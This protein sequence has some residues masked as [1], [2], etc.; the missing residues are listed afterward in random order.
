MTDQNIFDRLKKDHV[1]PGGTTNWAKLEK[2]GDTLKGTYIRERNFISPLYPNSNPRVFDIKDQNGVLVSYRSN[3]VLDE[4]FNGTKS[5][6]PIKPGQYV[7][8]TFLGMKP[9]KRGSM[10]DFQVCASPDIVDNSFKGAEFEEMPG[11]IEEVAKSFGG[12]VV[13]NTLPFESTPTMGTSSGADQREML[14]K[15]K[16]MAY[17]P[18]CDEANYKMKVLEITGLAMIPVNYDS[19]LSKLS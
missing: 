10:K 5:G 3:S 1:L 12:Q 15:Q 14:I 19:I 6:Q 16:A 11:D 18:G 2:Q 9:T 4:A 7:L 17:I 8:I 13:D